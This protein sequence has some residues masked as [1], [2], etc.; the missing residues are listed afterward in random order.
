MIKKVVRGVIA[1][2]VFALVPLA[3]AQSWPDR[4]IRLVVNF[5]VGGAP[6]YPL[7]DAAQAH[8]DLEAGRT[9]GASLL[10]P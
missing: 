6:D 9:T 3:A 10:I 1:V 5:G 8:A 4:P 2:S 7:A